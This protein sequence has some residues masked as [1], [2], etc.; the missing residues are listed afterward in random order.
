MSHTTT[1]ISPSGFQTIVISPQNP[2]SSG[3]DGS[4]GT[5][6]SAAATS[7]GKGVLIGLLSAFGTAFL[8]GIILLII[9]FFNFT[10]R[11][12]II[13]DRL[14]RPGEYDDEQ[15]F[16]KDEAEAL[17]EMDDMQRTEYMRAKGMV[18]TLCL[19]A[20]SCIALDIDFWGCQQRSS[21]RILPSPRTPTY[22]YRNSW[23]YRRRA[24][25]RGNLSP[26]SKSLIASSK[27]AHRSS[28]STASAACRA[29]CL[30]QNRTKSTIGKRRYTRSR[31]IH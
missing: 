3:S 21:K 2:L 17:E 27:V 24:F 6:F 18:H 30:Y 9:Y 25:P 5:K 23:P 1:Q 10:Q 16:V 11:G 26:N 13:L 8:V 20:H 19:P 15:Q 22:H 7:T 29:I 28:S 14:G 12:R 31:K 4:A